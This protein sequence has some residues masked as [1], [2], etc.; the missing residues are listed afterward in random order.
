MD[1]LCYDSYWIATLNH[2]HIE[3][4]FF[5]GEHT[6]TLKGISEVDWV[7]INRN[8]VRMFHWCDN[9][10][11]LL[12]DLGM[13]LGMF[14]GGFSTNPDIPFFGSHT[15]KSMEYNNRKFLNASI[16]YNME[17]R[18]IYEPDFDYNVI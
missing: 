11:V 16:G 7:D 18:S 8:G 13:S 15:T 14:L 10:N 3:S 17:P 5:H 12:E 1:L 2:V 9:Y 4:I 6:I